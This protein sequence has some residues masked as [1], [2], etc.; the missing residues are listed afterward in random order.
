LHHGQI[1]DKNEFEVYVMSFKYFRDGV[2]LNLNTSRS[3]RGSIYTPTIQDA[4]EAI[5]TL[6]SALISDLHDPFNE[7]GPLPGEEYLFC[8]VHLSITGLDNTA[9]NM[10]L[11]FN[12]N[13]PSGWKPFGFKDAKADLSMTINSGKLQSVGVPV[14]TGFHE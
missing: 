1:T 7:L 9:I 3:K 8:A 6:T 13:A 14:N 12:K 10:K 5:D 11:H 4:K 2:R